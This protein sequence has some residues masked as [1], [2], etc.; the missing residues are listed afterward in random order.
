MQRYLGA[1]LYHDLKETDL[2]E[3]RES[4]HE[5]ATSHTE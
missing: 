5:K 4:G 3:T 1:A 2:R